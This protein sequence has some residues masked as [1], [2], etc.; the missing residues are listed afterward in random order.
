[1]GLAL[2]KH[3]LARHHG[4]LAIESEPGHGATFTVRL[5]PSLDE[6]VINDNI[7]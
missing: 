2:V 3:I 7:R 4:R 5:P 1:L 6:T